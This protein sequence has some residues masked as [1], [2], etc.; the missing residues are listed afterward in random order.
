MNACW[1]DN[2]NTY[3]RCSQCHS[4][5]LRMVSLGYSDDDLAQH[6][7]VCRNCSSHLSLTLVTDLACTN[8]CSDCNIYA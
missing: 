6:G 2:A 8:L 3:K 5:R 1:S 4:E 7:I